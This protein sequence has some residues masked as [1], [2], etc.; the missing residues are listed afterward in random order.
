MSQETADG[1]REKSSDLTSAAPF[2]KLSRHS[3][4]SLNLFCAAPS[5]WVLERVL[6]RSQ[7]V[8]APAH[9]GVAVEAGVAY[10]LLNPTCDPQDSIDIAQQRYRE[11]IAL[12]PDLRKDK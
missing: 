5:M 4:S 8:G 12:S 3:P 1:P 10:G 7:P 11:L 2:A 9:R 6:G